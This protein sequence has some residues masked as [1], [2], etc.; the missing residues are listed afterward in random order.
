VVA[1]AGVEVAAAGP[2]GERGLDLVGAKGMAV[3]GMATG[4]TEAEGGGADG[5]AWE[6]GAMEWG[7]PPTPESPAVCPAAGCPPPVPAATLSRPP[8]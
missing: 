3:E 4:E 5:E 6:E 2:G 8:R 7:F 1:V